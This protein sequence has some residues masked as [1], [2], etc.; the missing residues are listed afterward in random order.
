MSDRLIRYLIGVSI[1]MFL[2]VCVWFVPCVYSRG[3]EGIGITCK[4]D[5]VAEGGN[6]NTLNFDYRQS[7]FPRIDTDIELLVSQTYAD[8]GCPITLGETRGYVMHV[9]SLISNEYGFL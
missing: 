2:G 7:L 1:L 5:T 3:G 8:S 9:D 4:G 6:A